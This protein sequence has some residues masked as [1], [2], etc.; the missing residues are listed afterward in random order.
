M[1]AE[2]ERDFQIMRLVVWGLGEGGAVL[3]CVRN[4]HASVL[5]I[6]SELAGRCRAC[7]V[8]SSVDSS[9]DKPAESFPRR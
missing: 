7:L 9:V 8:D 4:V 3:K 6:G 2:A 1:G 5:C